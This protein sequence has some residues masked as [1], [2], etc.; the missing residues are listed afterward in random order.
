MKSSSDLPRTQAQ[1]VSQRRWFVNVGFV[2]R[3]IGTFGYGNG[4]MSVRATT[5][6]SALAQKWWQRNRLVK[7][8]LFGSPPQALVAPGGDKCS[9]SGIL[10]L[11]GD[12][13]SRKQKAT[14]AQFGRV[15]RG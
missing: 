3:D 15:P 14:V 1:Q 7:A 4:W 8:V 10:H 6:S 5:S 11:S 2:V 12:A 13:A 9:H